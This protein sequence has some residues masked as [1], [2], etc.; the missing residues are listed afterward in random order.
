M[1]GFT[2]DVY[3]KRWQVKLWLGFTAVCTLRGGTEATAGFTTEQIYR[4]VL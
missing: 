1:V 4:F 2:T 3:F